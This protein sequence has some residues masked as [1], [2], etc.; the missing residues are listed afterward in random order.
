MLCKYKNMKLIS[1]WLTYVEDIRSLVGFVGYNLSKSIRSI[2]LKC[3]L[4]S[5][6]TVVPKSVDRSKVLHLV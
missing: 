2:P 4:K 6:A 3:L 5:N 1:V